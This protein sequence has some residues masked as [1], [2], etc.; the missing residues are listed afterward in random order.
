MKYP[1]SIL[2]VGLCLAA[3]SSD[4]P[5]GEVVAPTDVTIYSRANGATTESAQVFLWT[6]QDYLSLLGAGTLAADLAPYAQSTMPNEIDAYN[7]DPAQNSGTTYNTFQT[8]P[9]QND[10]IYATGIAPSS[11]FNVPVAVGGYEEIEV[12]NTEC[13]NG[14]T[15]FLATINDGRSRGRGKAND[16]FVVSNAAYASQNEERELKFQHL[17]ASIAIVAKRDKSTYEKIG[18]RNIDVSIDNSKGQLSVP[19][20]IKRY[21][22][23]SATAFETDGSLSHNPEINA[24]TYIVGKEISTIPEFSVSTD[25]TI[26]MDEEILLTRIYANST[27]IE[28]GTAVN[29]FDPLA[30]DASNKLVLN[31]SA[32]EL[33]KQPTLTLH[34][35]YDVFYPN[36]QI[37]SQR[38]SKDVTVRSW[39]LTTLSDAVSTG[40]R[41]LPGFYYQVTLNFKPDAVAVEAS[42][43]PWTEI[44][45]YY[46]TIWGSET[47]SI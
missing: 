43:L 46:Y 14:Y 13:Q 31:L 37:E 2:I 9:T 5:K 1:F 6:A 35:E 42:L 40:S 27:G 3:C 30:Y 17:T 41:F 15:D 29:Q 38:L 16:F 25:Y 4:T 32:E 19:A 44:G 7:Y 11:A 21:R 39:D 45:P 34:L 33:A 36:S 24:W 12:T 28:Y 23:G 22:V 18:I 47:P 10:Y 20:S 26:P 8:Y